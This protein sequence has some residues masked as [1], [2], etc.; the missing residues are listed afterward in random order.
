MGA[1]PAPGVQQS[2][3]RNVSC[4]CSDGFTGSF[5]GGDSG[6][7]FRAGF[8]GELYGRLYGRSLWWCLQA[9]GLAAARGKASSSWVKNT[10]R[11]VVS[12]S[13]CCL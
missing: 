8:T 4:S 12:R 3:L 2:A 1:A 6:R 13:G 7:T 11:M 5:T 10:G 9:G